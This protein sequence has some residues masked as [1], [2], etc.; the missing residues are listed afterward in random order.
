MSGRPEEHNKG[1]R[2]HQ[3][4][5]LHKEIIPEAK[6]KET[7]AQGTRRS[8]GDKIAQRS[9]LKA[10]V[11]REFHILANPSS[12]T[13][14]GGESPRRAQEQKKHTEIVQNKFI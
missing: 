13:R 1:P 5:K 2:E 7:R 11:E 6:I 14:Q 10:A 8:P 3:G 4:A 12:K 9:F